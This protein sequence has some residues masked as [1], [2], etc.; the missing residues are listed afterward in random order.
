VKPAAGGSLAGADGRNMNQLPTPQA[1]EPTR[2]RLRWSDVADALGSGWRIFRQIPGPSI[3]YA[4][5]FVLI[6]AVLLTALGIFGISPM[7]LPFAGGFMLVGPILL[8]GYFEL[9]R[10]HQAGEAATL[11]SALRGF[12]RAPLG[13]WLIAVLCSF[14]FLIWITDAGVLYAFTLGGKSL[15]YDF[16][17]IRQTGIAVLHF[18]AWASVMGS[19]IAF[20]IFTLSA[21]SVP[22]LYEQRAGT[23]Q[24]INLSVRTVFGNLPICLSWGLILSVVIMASIL[25]LPLLLL[26][27]PVMAYAS[28]TLY[29]AAFPTA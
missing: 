12:R 14:L 17:W 2:A 28:F 19:A 29:R 25:L 9:V 18:Q 7:A 4:L 24:A 11:V 15:G 6:G 22:L 13:T 10:S 20:L 3:L 23:L 26:S 16:D 27:L 8:T 21:F 1:G 5:L